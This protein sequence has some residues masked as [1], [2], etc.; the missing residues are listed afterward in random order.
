MCDRLCDLRTQRI[1]SLLLSSQRYSRIKC[2]VNSPVIYNR[3]GAR[4]TTLSLTTVYTHSATSRPKLHAF[5]LVAQTVYLRAPSHRGRHHRLRRLRV[6]VTNAAARDRQPRRAARPR[7]R[8]RVRARLV[9]G[10]ARR[11]AWQ[12]RLLGGGSQRSTSLRQPQLHVLVRRCELHRGTPRRCLR[13]H[14]GARSE[15][16]ADRQRGAGLSGPVQRGAARCI[17]VVHERGAALEP[18]ALEQLAQQRRARAQPDRQLQ[19]RLLPLASPGSERTQFGRRQNGA[20][21]NGQSQPPGHRRR[22]TSRG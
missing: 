14:V 6:V 8:P 5:D 13:V 7:V 17:A 2:V 21:P 19:Y 11:R 9:R 1:F 10:G 16:R 12:R 15:Q 4:F 18:R 22:A 20:T 3:C